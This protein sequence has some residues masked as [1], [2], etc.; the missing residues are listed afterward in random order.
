MRKGNRKKGK[1]KVIHILSILF[2]I[3]IVC[4]LVIAGL[5]LIYSPGKPAPFLDESGQPIES[6]ISEKVFVTIGGVKQGMFI[7]GKDIDNPVLLFVHGGPC[8]PEYFLAE[9]YPSGIEDYFTVCYWEERGGGLSYG[10]DVTAGSMTLEQLTADTIEVTKYLQDRFGKD[11]IYLMAHSGGTAFAIK[12][13]AEE[14]E[15]Y[16]AYIGISQITWPA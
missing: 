16:D 7:R 3:L 11:K 12:A 5:L 14:P 8:F 13:A 2:I 1:G 15:L 9:K 10:K 6:S 4:I